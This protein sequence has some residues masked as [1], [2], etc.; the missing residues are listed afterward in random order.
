[1]PPDTFTSNT[2]APPVLLG[3]STLPTI[4]V[5]SRVSE[6][7]WEPEWRFFAGPDSV[8]D[9]NTAELHRRAAMKFT[10]IL[11]DLI[12]LAGRRNAAEELPPRSDPESP[13]FIECD[14]PRPIPTPEGVALREFLAS[15]TDAQLYAALLLMDL[16]RDESGGM[17]VWREVLEVKRSQF[18]RDKALQR[19]RSKQPL[20]DF[21]REGRRKFE[22]L[23]Q[24]LDDLTP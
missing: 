9:W 1:M 20:P 24:D 13:A 11:N 17:F 21:L 22:A 14:D 8:V 6:L 18:T 15:L 16:G 4:G 2:T 7:C 5:G 12:D 10:Q 3:T 23:G 19:M